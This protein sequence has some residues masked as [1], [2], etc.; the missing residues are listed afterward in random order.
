MPKAWSQGLHAHKATTRELAQGKKIMLSTQHHSIQFIQSLVSFQNV[1]DLFT[2][3]VSVS[4]EF[5]LH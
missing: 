5:K 1:N 3:S 2:F 4:L